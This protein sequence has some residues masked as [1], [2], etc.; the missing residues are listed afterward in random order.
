MGVGAVQVQTG[1]QEVTVAPL[2]M[3]PVDIPSVLRVSVLAVSAVVMAVGI[4]VMIGF[5]V[6]KYFP[7]DYRIIMG[8]V[9]FLYGAYRFVVTYFHRKGGLPHG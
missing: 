6:P 9:V 4:L 7:E 3:V 1:R 8:V 5:L 2:W